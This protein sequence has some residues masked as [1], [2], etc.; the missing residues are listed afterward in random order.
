M[1]AL[2]GSVVQGPGKHHWRGSA[3]QHTRPTE[4]LS[5]P[6]T[7]L[8]PQTTVQDVLCHPLL[9]EDW[10]GLPVQGLELGEWNWERKGVWK[11]EGRK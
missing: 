9:Q 11:E 6:G 5:C 3:L 7:D 8:G 1:A 10:A 4:T 2:L